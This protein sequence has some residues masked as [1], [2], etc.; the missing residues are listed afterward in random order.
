VTDP[1]VVLCDEPSGGLDPIS[2]GRLDELLLCLKDDFGMTFVVVTHE[3]RSIAKVADHILVL[4][5]GRLHFS[6]GRDEVM[7]SDDP[8]VRT[9]FLRKVDHD[10]A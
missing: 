8:F 4:N 2:S 9:F 7:G 10:D 1:A 3:L 6:G 5:Q